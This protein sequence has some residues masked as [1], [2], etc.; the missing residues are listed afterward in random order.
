[1]MIKFK[2]DKVV[3]LEKLDRDFIFKRGYSYY[4]SKIKDGYKVW[5][6]DKSVVVEIT[7]DGVR[8]YLEV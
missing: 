3:Y 2:R 4:G 7:G 6:I 5:N 1:M 8:E